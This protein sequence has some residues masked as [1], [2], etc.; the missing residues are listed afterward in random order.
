MILITSVITV[1]ISEPL[2]A[3]MIKTFG[4]WL[5]KKD[6]DSRSISAALNI[7]E[8]V[9]ESFFDRSK[10]IEIQTD[11][12]MLEFGKENPDCYKFTV[13]EVVKRWAI[14]EALEGDENED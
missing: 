5:L 6:G 4:H 7:V 12:T 3:I 14:Q 8:G 13:E 10:N 9:K 2:G 1:I 11:F